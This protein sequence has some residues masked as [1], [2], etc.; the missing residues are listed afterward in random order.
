RR[1]VG[2]HLPDYMVPAALVALTALPLTPNGK[3]DRKAL[4]APDF[5]MLSHR[6]YAAP[7]GETEEAIARLF[8]GLLGV[9]RVGR[10]DGFFELGGHSLLAMRLVARIRAELDVE[11]SV[12]TIFQAPD[13]M[14]LAEKVEH[15]YLSQFDFNELARFI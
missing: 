12:R 4:P 10:H 6:V 1:Y 9:E 8:G 7:E 14:S 13:V 3:L 11:I 5:T 2:E 15:L